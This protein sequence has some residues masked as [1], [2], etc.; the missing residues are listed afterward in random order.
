[1]IIEQTK[2]VQGSRR[3]QSVGT[4]QKRWAMLGDMYCTA[5]VVLS[6]PGGTQYSVRR[7]GA[8]I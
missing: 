2:S 6:F 4:R 8:G 3:H 1:M 5:T 7:G